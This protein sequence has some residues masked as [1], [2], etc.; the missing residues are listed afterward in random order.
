MSG[1]ATIDA[2]KSGLEAYRKKLTESAHIAL[3]APDPRV[4]ERLAALLVKRG[5]TVH[6]FETPAAF[7]AWLG[8][9]P[10]ALGVFQVDDPS[11]DGLAL[12]G[13]LRE[14][15][16]LA[17]LIA[18]ARNPDASLAVACME[19]G[20]QDL[21]AIPVAHEDV[22]V[23]RARAAI[24]R[25]RRAAID[26]RIT[27]TFQGFANSLFRKGDTRQRQ[28]LAGFAKTLI[29]YKRELAEH[30][31]ILVI[32][33]NRFNG[34]RT[35]SFLESEGYRVTLAEKK[36][37]AV[38]I[39]AE[40][41]PRLVLADAELPDG[42]AFDA[43]KELSRISPDIEFLIVSSANALD[44]AVEAMALGARDCVLKPHE[45]LEAI[46]LKVKRALSLQAKHHKH[47]RLVY[48]LR[49]LCSE[50]VA[51]DAEAK[52]EGAVMVKVDPGASQATLNRFLA[53]LDNEE[54]KRIREA[55]RYT[56]HTAPRSAPKP[57]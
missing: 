19:R 27:E 56:T 41:E 31:E 29:D 30:K 1:K 5:L 20:T 8:K 24:E 38:T 44:V 2:L 33:A 25:F 28:A 34:D 26:N 6:A 15:E 42:T 4:S 17:E 22:F 13:K 48:E 40:S 55:G 51:I 12:L 53:E 54:Q 57:A 21:F 45:G 14:K 43:Y 39:A 9:E 50:L 52:K 7:L 35:K 10:V 18:L 46:Q 32:A 36:A 16:P 37:E 11:F 23:S 49:K 3:V 47:Q